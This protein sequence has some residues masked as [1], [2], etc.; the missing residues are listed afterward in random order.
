MTYAGEHTLVGNIGHVFVILSFVLIGL[1]GIAYFNASRSP[2]KYLIWIKTARRLFFA[3]VLTALTFIVLIFF[4]L[5]NHYYEYEYIWEQS[6]EDM[7]FRYL[8]VCFW[9]GQEGS[10][11]LWIFWHLVLGSIL[12]FTSKKFE[13]QVMTIFCL[14]QFFLVSMLLGVYIGDF[15]FGSSPFALRRQV[16]E[17]FGPLWNLIP[18]YFTFDD[19]LKI[20]KGLNPLLRNYWMTIHPPTLFLGF[21]LTLVPFCYAI[22]GLWTKRLTEWIKPALPWTFFGIMVLGGGILMG[23]RWAYESLSFGGFWAWDPVENASL[24]PWIVL[25]GAGHLMLINRNNRH[26]LYS[27]FILT[28]FSFILILLSTFLT[29]SGIL[30]DSSVHS[31]TGKDMLGQLLL[32]M[33]FFV[34]LSVHLLLTKRIHRIILASI[35]GGIFIIAF[36]ASTHWISAFESFGHSTYFKPFLFITG[37][38]A[39]LVFMIIGYSTFPKSEEYD[40]NFSAREFWMFIGAIVL[41]LSAFHIIYNT[42]QP[43]LNDI[44][45]TKRV[46]SQDERNG[47]YNMYQVPFVVILSLLMAFSQFLKYK[48]TD[49]R[50]FLKEILIS[51]GFSLIFS[52]LLLPKVGMSSSLPHAL[53]LFTAIFAVVANLDY[54]LRLMKGKLNHLGSSIAHVGFALVLLGALISQANQQVISKNYKGYVLDFLDKDGGIKNEQDVQLFKGE[55]TSMGEYFVVYKGKRFEP[56]DGHLFYDV[57]YLEQLPV[58]YKPGD[59]TRFNFQLF[60]CNTKH[61]ARNTF[62]EEA[63]YWKPVDAASSEEYYSYPTWESKKPG[64]VLF[65]LVPFVQ[66]NKMSNVAEP[67]TKN[68]WSHDIFTHIK[69]ADL[70]PVNT[71]KMQAFKMNG[72]VGDTLWT[73]GYKVIIEDVNKVQKDTNSGNIGA[74]LRLK[75]YSIL[76]SKAKYPFTV[77]PQY[78]IDSIGNVN[79]PLSEIKSLG[80][81]FRVMSIDP[82]TPN[83]KNPSK[84]GSFEMEFVTNEYLVLHATKFPMI[85]ILWW[86]CII[87]CFG[88]LM[89][90]INRIKKNKLAKA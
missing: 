44:F 16:N 83:P 71:G 17:A 68:F 49:S 19:N 54:F 18:D 41:C 84:A 48:K 87:M 38:L 10:F 12:V 36:L 42:S 74:K 32:Y 58:E 50:K 52:G 56:K 47:F 11:M 27:T 24:V 77:E 81:Q 23:G 70:S 46:I 79:N 33:L 28:Q 66:L 73:A 20:G 3:H 35:A 2:E 13:P 4:L 30:G 40:E 88:T 85:I 26:S 51:F 14:V 31:F 82:E 62:V 7:S 76:D 60:E 75:I 80:L 25:I 45:G 21:A 69:Y 55:L 43:A 72:K 64:K 61:V 15:K 89:A 86:G 90:V 65:T 34:W 1:S 37:L 63:G 39:M 5:V 67:G 6:S 29:R 59:R 22:A 78:L 57:D 9:G 53:L 8:L